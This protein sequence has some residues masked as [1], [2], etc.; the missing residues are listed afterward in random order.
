MLHR[1]SLTIEPNL[2]DSILV[3]ADIERVNTLL[4]N[5]LSNAIKYSPMG[6]C[7]RIDVRRD[8]H[9]IVLDVADEGPGIEESDKELVFEPFY[10]SNA[11]ETQ[12]EGTGIGLSLVRECLRTH[13]GEGEFITTGRGAHFRAHLPI[14]HAGEYAA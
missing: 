5:L 12:A 7:I 11:L 6:G 9:T 3:D 10:Q 14:I 4:A 1:K 8:A 13:G 2:P